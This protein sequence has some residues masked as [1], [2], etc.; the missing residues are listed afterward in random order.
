MFRSM[1]YRRLSAALLAVVGLSIVLGGTAGAV[2][3]VTGKQIKDGTVRGRDVGNGSLSGADVA[4]RSLT[5]ADFNGS[6]QGPPGPDGAQGPQG[7]KG[8]QGVAGSAGPQGAK[9]DPGA[10]GISGLRYVMS[11]G[12]AVTAG[13]WRGLYIYCDDQKVLGG[14][15][16]TF[17]DSDKARVVQSAPLTGGTGWYVKVRNE[18]SSDL[19][20]FGWASCATVAP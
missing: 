2:S 3:L 8:D 18:G 1:R 11:Q 16:S 6:V 5:A 12:A 20:A 15:V 13:S 17:P 4:D 19:T 14:G 10:P 9:G 7:P